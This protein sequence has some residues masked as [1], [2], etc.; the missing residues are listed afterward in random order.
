MKTE[1]TLFP[2]PI[3]QLHYTDSVTFNVHTGRNTYYV[4]L[5][6]TKTSPFTMN[7]IRQDMEKLAKIPLQLTLVSVDD[8]SGDLILH[9]EPSI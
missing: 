1:R 4:Y 6:D 5:A 7:A 3:E 8:I 2:I 9:F